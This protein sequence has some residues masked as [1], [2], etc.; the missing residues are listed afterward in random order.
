MDSETQKVIYGHAE[1]HMREIASLTKIMTCY[2]SLRLKE[3]FQVDWDTLVK[4]SST[5]AGINGT[6]AKL[7]SGDCIKF[8]DLLFGLMLP[9]GNDAAWAL[10]EFFGLLLNPKTLKPAS[11]F[12]AEMNNLARE[13]D[14]IYTT[15]NNPHGLTFKKNVSAAKDVC[16]LAG[17]AM[18]NQDFCRIVNTP[19]YSAEIKGTEGVREQVWENTNKMLGRGFKGVKTGVTSRAGP[20]LCVASQRNSKD[21]VITILGSRSMDAR[22]AEVRKLA[23]WAEFYFVNK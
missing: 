15:Y 10:A 18:Q 2:L 23:D 20:C 16:K 6:S 1:T 11:C 14:L 13:L 21:L 3:K 12:I 9:S 7:Q 5:A 8:I 22:W 4:V 19:K 17:T